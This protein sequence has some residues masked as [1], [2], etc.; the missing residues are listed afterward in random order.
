MPGSIPLCTSSSALDRVTF[1]TLAIWMFIKDQAL[2]TPWQM[3]L[4]PQVPSPQNTF[5]TGPSSDGL[6][7]G[8]SSDSSCNHASSQM[9]CSIHLFLFLFLFFSCLKVFIKAWESTQLGSKAQ[10]HGGDNSTAGKR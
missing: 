1:L 7:A 4:V 8:V 3:F 5:D 10:K 9:C 6:V 2:H